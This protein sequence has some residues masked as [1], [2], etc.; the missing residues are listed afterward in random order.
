M[1]VDVMDLIRRLGNGEGEQFKMMKDPDDPTHAVVLKARDLIVMWC[2]VIRSAEALAECCSNIANDPKLSRRNKIK[3]ILERVKT[4][5]T[6]AE[7]YLD[8]D[9]EKIEHEIELLQML[10]E[11]KEDINRI[12]KEG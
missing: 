11:E 6:L 3:Q 8:D 10:K 2:G 4:V 12:E 7:G 9:I 1:K 5:S